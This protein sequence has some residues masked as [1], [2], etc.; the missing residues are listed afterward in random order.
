MTRF[1]KLALASVGATFLPV[2]VGGVVRATGSGDGC[3]DWPRCFGKLVPPF[4]YHAII[5]YSHRTV[6]AVS[7][8]VLL[9]L[10]IVL[11]KYYRRAPALLWPGLSA[12]PLVMVQAYLGKL[13]VEN[14]LSPTL[15]TLHLATAMALGGVLIVLTVNA[16]YYDRERPRAK[17]ASAQKGGATAVL[18]MAIATTTATFAL[19]LIGAYLRARDAAL[20]FPDWPLMDKSLLPSLSGPGALIHFTHRVGALVVAILLTAL[21]I[22]VFRLAGRGKAMTRLVIWTDGFFLAE[23]LLGAF[24]V[25]VRIPPWARALHV[26]FSTLT[27]GAIVALTGVAYH[28]YRSHL[29]LVELADVSGPDSEREANGD[30]LLT[31]GRLA[32]RPVTAGVDG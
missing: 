22:L 29:S 27:W 15:V 13:V 10:A 28:R 23:V 24:N 9:W 5:E 2:V 20:A 25:L 30:R 4:E 31:P 18:A 17:A 26:I 16:F 12:F 3:P 11:I 21:S 14:G 6:A 8:F 1:Q 19:I 32:P 7:G